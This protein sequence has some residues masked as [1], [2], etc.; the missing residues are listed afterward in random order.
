MFDVSF[1]IEG[2]PVAKGR[3]KFARRG[4]FV[5]VYTPKK[6]KTYEDKVAE[7]AR[8]AMGDQEPLETPVTVSIMIYFPVPASYSKKRREACLNQT[9]MHLK[10]PDMDNVYKAITDAMNGIVYQDDCQI[11]SMHVDK[12]YADVGSVSV[13]VYEKLA[14][15]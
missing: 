13:Y 8:I 6:T 2:D 11:V 10:R 7:V 4:K 15:K 1:I 9:E 3:P 14:L 12:V 5:S